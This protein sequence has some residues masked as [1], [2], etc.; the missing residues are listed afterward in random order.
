MQP[1][2]LEK[3]PER[4]AQ[5]P[6]Q[7]SPGDILAHDS[8]EGPPSPLSEASS[9]YFS[10]S[11]S[12]ATLSE[13]L[14]LGNDAP[15]QAGGQTPG[16]SDAPPTVLPTQSAALVLDVSV[17][18]ASALASEICPTLEGGD[19]VA[20]GLK[21]DSGRVKDPNK[22]NDA[23]NSRSKWIASS[24][25]S[26]EETATDSKVHPPTCSAKTPQLVPS[27][28]SSPADLSSQHGPGS[29]PFK[30][31][32]VKTSELKSFSDMLGGEVGGFS[33]P[34]EEKMGGRSKHNSHG[35]GTAGSPTEEKLEVLSD[36]E[37]ANEIPGWLKE[38][39]YVMVGTNKTGTVRYVGPTDFQAGTWVGVELDLPSGM[40]WTGSAIRVQQ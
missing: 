1:T 39:E 28:A 12:T 36:S 2:Q 31:Q 40:H 32:R 23:G 22:G 25:A 18:S 34:E 10:H 33:N 27:H 13:S 15:L 24:V 4:A 7:P 19:S 38:G 8:Q 17:K 16:R 35:N 11:V 30:I 37:E 20:P 9:G 14:A 29:S 6:L 21:G 5:V 26:S 3:T